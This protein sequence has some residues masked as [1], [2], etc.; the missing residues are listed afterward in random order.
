MGIPRSL[1][2]AAMRLSGPSLSAASILPTLPDML[3]AGRG[4]NRSRG[5]DSSDA[6]PVAGS[7]CKIIVT[8]LRAPAPC[9]DE[10]NCAASPG[11]RPVRVFEPINK[12]FIGFNPEEVTPVAARHDGH[13][14]VLSCDAR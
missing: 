7:R 11:S 2:M 4:T 8:S 3:C 14:A 10:P 13:L 1:V 12:M 6:E 9:D 5:I